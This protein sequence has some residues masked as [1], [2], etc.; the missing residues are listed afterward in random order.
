MD[1]GFDSSFILLDR[2]LFVYGSFAKFQKIRKTMKKYFFPIVVLVCC[3]CCVNLTF[4]QDESSKYRSKAVDALRTGPDENGRKTV[5]LYLDAQLA[6]WEGDEARIPLFKKDL[7]ESLQSVQKD[8]PK[9]YVLAMDMIFEGLKEMAEGGKRAVRFNAVLMAG[10]LDQPASD[11]TTVPYAKALPFLKEMAA[12]DEAYIQVAAMKGLARQARYAKAEDKASLAKIFSQFAFAPLAKGEANEAP[13]AQ[14]LRLQALEALGNLRMAGSKGEIAGKLLGSAM[15]QTKVVESPYFR[16]DME[17]RITAAVAFSKLKLTADEM[18][19]MKKKPEEITAA[20][21]RLFLVCMKYEYDNDYDLQEGVEGE[22]QRDPRARRIA[23]AMSP[24]EEAYQIRLW[25]QR[26]KAISSAFAWIF[27]SKES[28]LP[29]LEASNKNFSK[30]ARM[31]RDISEMY[32]RAGLSKRRTASRSE[33][34]EEAD[35]SMDS[36]VV[37]TDG[38]LTLYQ[39]QK[40]MRTALR[41]LAEL[42]EIPLDIQAKMRPDAG[43]GY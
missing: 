11:G 5:K 6:R 29:V 19:A 35:A 4:G 21:G 26:T 24:E 13:E 40:D 34:S 25:K 17:R 36:T 27:N 22:V 10:E 38:K 32:D 1:R 2:R 23:R 28:N 12:A 30:V 41:D 18:R 31:I 7:L 20:F 9:N 43:Y 42:M 39:M 8:N 15:M 37:S 16:R 3:F 33:E 14:W